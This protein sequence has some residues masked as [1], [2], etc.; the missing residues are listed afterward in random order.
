M[1]KTKQ[2]NKDI[3]MEGQSAIRSVGVEEKVGPI[4]TDG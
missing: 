1:S 3:Y 4:T 2:S